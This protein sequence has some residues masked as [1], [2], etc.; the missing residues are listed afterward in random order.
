[1]GDLFLATHVQ[2]I[3]RGALST[4]MLIMLS[5]FPAGRRLD[6]VRN[7]TLRLSSVDKCGASRAC[8]VHAAT[9]GVEQ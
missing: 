9:Y 2:R 3:A 4:G 7:I 8:R 5:G 6:E 1:M